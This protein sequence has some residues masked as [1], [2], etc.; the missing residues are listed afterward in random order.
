MIRKWLQ[1]NVL[2]RLLDTEMRTLNPSPLGQIRPQVVFEEGLKALAIECVPCQAD[3]HWS[4][5]PGG[6]T[7]PSCGYFVDYRQTYSMFLEVRSM[8]DKMSGFLEE[9]TFSTSDG[10]PHKE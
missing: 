5:H 8:I 2:K 10:N 3:M 1:R 6:W 7:C 9:Q 4:E